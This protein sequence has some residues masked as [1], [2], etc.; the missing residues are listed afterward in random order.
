MECIECSVIFTNANLLILHLKRDHLKQSS[1]EFTCKCSQVFT[2]I[3]RF[4]RHLNNTHAL[5]KNWHL[6]G[7]TVLEDSA[8]N[9]DLEMS[10]PPAP[11]AKTY[12]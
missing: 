6:G 12:F 5:G 4:K 10:G 2:N 8:E 1:D 3:N 9:E 7:Q 11:A